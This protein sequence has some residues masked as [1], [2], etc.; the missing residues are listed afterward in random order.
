MKKPTKEQINNMSMSG[1]TLYVCFGRWGGVRIYTDM[2]LI[3]TIG[4]ISI[5]FIFI[6]IEVFKTK[7]YNRLVGDIDER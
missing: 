5:G 1:L 6:D 2:G 3:I 7:V 4:F